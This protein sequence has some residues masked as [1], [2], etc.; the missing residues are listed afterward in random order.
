M[1]LCANKSKHMN[2]AHFQEETVAKLV[3]RRHA[4]EIQITGESAHCYTQ[5][6][7]ISAAIFCSGFGRAMTAHMHLFPKFQ[8]LKIVR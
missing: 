1:L 5:N 8:T 4:F 7:K 3:L 6:K 2:T